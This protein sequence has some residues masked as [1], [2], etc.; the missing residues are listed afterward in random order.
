MP[1]A[2]QAKLDWKTFD[3]TKVLF[4]TWVVKDLIPERST[5]CVYGAP[6]TGKSFLVLDMAL[7]VAT[8]KPW[9]GKETRVTAGKIKERGKVIYILAE[10][11]EGLHRRIA[12]WLEHNKISWDGDVEELS[13]HFFI[14]VVENIFLDKPNDL[15]RLIG[16]IG[17]NCADPALIIFDPL[18]SFMSG[19]E[20][21]AR[22]TQAMIQGVR[23]LVE[24]YQQANCTVLLVHH[25]GKEFARAERG[26]SALRGGLETLIELQR[27]RL[28]LH[29]QRDAMKHPDIEIELSTVEGTSYDGVSGDLGK[30]VTGGRVIP[31]KE[32]KTADSDEAADN[33]GSTASSSKSA[34]KKKEDPRKARIRANQDLI[35]ATIKDL[36][37]GQTDQTV[38]ATTVLEKLKQRKKGGF[39]G[40]DSTFYSLIGKL[41]SK[42]DNQPPALKKGEDG[43]YSVI[44][45]PDAPPQDA[46]Y[47]SGVPSQS[48]PSRPAE[49]AAPPEG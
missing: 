23:K 35:I 41:T 14:P 16:E 45:Y 26:S 39:D 12:A 30:V 49:E 37:K 11:P 32:Y 5:C 18:V 6:N 13:G 7:A 36:T 43:R 1:N 21:S 15:D 10:G 34:T 25:S 29:K 48:D 2:S 3:R 27:N 44:V 46:V 24:T 9:L 17:N 8:G 4:P 31:A 22:D 19:D 42:I 47:S 20:N 28:K 38:A 40:K 33:G